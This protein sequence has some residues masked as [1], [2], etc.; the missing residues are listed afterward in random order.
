M[1][2]KVLRWCE[3]NQ[4]SYIVGQ[5]HHEGIKALT[6]DFRKKVAQDF[7]ETGEDQ[8]QFME[9]EYCTKDG[10]KFR[11]IIVKVEHTDRG[12]N[13]RC[14]V[15]NL[16]GDRQE[17]YDQVYCARGDMENRIKEQQLGLFADRTS[18]SQWWSNQLRLLLSTFAYI[19]LDRLRTQALKGTDWVKKQCSTLQVNLIKIGAVITRNT[20]KVR[21]HLSS[22]YPHQDIFEHA[23]LNLMSG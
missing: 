3:K 16:K 11:R 7:T 21:I 5:A 14:I 18:T 13:V 2:R 1:R 4:V 12:E 10:T 8:R 15:T 9:C 20:R 19:L 6:A 23:Y 17:L 22:S